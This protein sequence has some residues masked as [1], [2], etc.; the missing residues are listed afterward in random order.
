MSKSP[1]FILLDIVEPSFDRSYI[2][3]IKVNA[4]IIPAEKKLFDEI[5]QKTDVMAASFLN[6]YKIK[7]DSMFFLDSKISK[8]HVIADFYN[9]I[10]NDF[11]Q[12]LNILESCSFLSEKN[13]IRSDL[14]NIGRKVDARFQYFKAKLEKNENEDSKECLQEAISDINT[15]ILSIKQSIDE[16]VKCYNKTLDYFEFKK[17]VVCKVYFLDPQK[18]DYEIN[19]FQDD[20]NSLFKPISNFLHSECYRY[21][22]KEI[23]EKFLR[24]ADKFKMETDRLYVSIP[25]IKCLEFFQKLDNIKLRHQTILENKDMINLFIDSKTK[26]MVGKL[27]VFENALIV[28]ILKIKEFCSTVSVKLNAK[29]R[30]PMTLDAMTMTILASFFNKSVGD[31]ATMKDDDFNRFVSIEMKGL[32]FTVSNKQDIDTESMTKGWVFPMKLAYSLFPNKVNI[33]WESLKIN[34]LVYNFNCVKIDEDT[35]FGLTGATKKEEKMLY[36]EAYHWYAIGLPNKKENYKKIIL[37]KMCMVEY[38]Q[39]IVVSKDL[40]P[41]HF[42]IQCSYVI[43]KCLLNNGVPMTFKSMD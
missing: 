27:D 26:E 13:D 2:C 12:E 4:D 32:I 25:V 7:L 23:S 37:Q 40:Y 42:K 17:E 3:N 31:A 29:S 9:Y 6:Y 33:F 18:H 15:A 20:T 1:Y 19:F 16:R 5:K 39:E 11:N 22:K 24:Y 41:M 10:Q 14:R 36:K 30:F 8:D 34:K 21:I 28:K 38:S 43:E 35:D